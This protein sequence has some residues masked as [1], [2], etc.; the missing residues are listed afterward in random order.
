MPIKISIRNI[1]KITKTMQMI[2]TA[3]NRR[4]FP[5][6]LFHPTLGSDTAARS[7]PHPP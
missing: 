1:R 3:K 6:R 7:P 5:F 2:A 4:H